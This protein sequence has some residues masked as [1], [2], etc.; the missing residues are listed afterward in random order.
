MKSFVKKRVLALLLT[1]VMAVS[2][3]RGV[4]AFAQETD[5]EKESLSG[6]LNWQ[7]EGQPTS[8][9]CGANAKWSFDRGNKVLIQ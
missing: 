7:S 3:C 2:F 5:A 8:G 9:S 1:V 4:E 6:E